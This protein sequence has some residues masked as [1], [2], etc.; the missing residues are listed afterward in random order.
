M[1]NCCSMR[2]S[3]PNGLTLNVSPFQKKGHRIT[4]T[5]EEVFDAV[6]KAVQLAE[7][8]KEAPVYALEILKCMKT[9]EDI[10]CP[11]LRKILLDLYR[12]D[13]ILADKEMNRWSLDVRHQ[14]SVMR[15]T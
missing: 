5:T 3:N 10:R 11:D 8:K 13:A 9:T 15:Q 12:E 2:E 7:T 4:D 1:G 6:K 14:N